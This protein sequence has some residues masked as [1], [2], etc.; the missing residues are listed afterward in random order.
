MLHYVH[1]SYNTELQN[2]DLYTQQFIIFFPW[3]LQQTTGNSDH[4]TYNLSTQA[5]F[6]YTFEIPC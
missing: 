6:L 2:V 4:N 5:F 3:L 1:R